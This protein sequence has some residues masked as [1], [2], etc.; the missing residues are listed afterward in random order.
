MRLPCCYHALVNV[1]F[2]PDTNPTHRIYYHDVVDKRFSTVFDTIVGDI[3]VSDLLPSKF[4]C[5]AQIDI[6]PARRCWFGVSEQDLR[7]S[8]VV[9]IAQDTIR[10]HC[11]G[12]RLEGPDTFSAPQDP[13][14]PLVVKYFM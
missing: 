4:F 8:A 5:P 9:P 3:V 14:W 10:R 2:V 6:C 7:L 12:T 13:S 1:S 11:I